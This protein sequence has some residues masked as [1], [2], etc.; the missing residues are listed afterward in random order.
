M[1]IDVQAQAHWRVIFRTFPSPRDARRSGHLDAS[2]HGP[3]GL[4]RVLMPPGTGIQI[5]SPDGAGFPE[6]SVTRGGVVVAGGR[7]L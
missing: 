7:S 1:A 4:P 2:V 6:S 5:G 3:D